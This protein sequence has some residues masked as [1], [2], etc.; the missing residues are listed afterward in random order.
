MCAEHDD[1][2]ECIVDIE[3]RVSQLTEVKHHV[4]VNTTSAT[5]VLGGGRATP[6]SVSLRRSNSVRPTVHVAEEEVENVQIKRGFSIGV[7]NGTQE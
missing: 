2:V 7:N 4:S 5:T 6:G 3:S 1:V